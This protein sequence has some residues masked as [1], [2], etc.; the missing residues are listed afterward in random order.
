MSEMISAAQTG[1]K[2]KGLGK[3]GTSLR[4]KEGLDKK[5]IVKSVGIKE[6]AN[7]TT[8]YQA[9][10]RDNISVEKAV[11]QQR[12]RVLVKSLLLGKSIL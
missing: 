12:N 5:G 11:E 7:L 4:K 9:N 10:R 6:R 8:K 2:R 3:I 1:V